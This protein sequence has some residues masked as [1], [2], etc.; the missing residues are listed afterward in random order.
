MTMNIKKAI[1]FPLFA[2]SICVAFTGCK[3]TYYTFWEKLGKEKR[4]LL[5]DNVVKA[6]DEQE[7]AKTEFKDALTR[8]REL[9]GFDGGKLEQAYKQVEKDYKQCNDRAESVRSRITKIEGIADDLFAEWEKE[10]ASYSSENL[11]AISRTKLRETR[12]RF[13]ELRLALRKSAASM[14]PVLAKLKDQTLF[15]KHNLNAQAIGSLKG[16]VISIEADVQKLIAEMN[17]SIAQAEQFIK[18][19]E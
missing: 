16:K 15:L 17:A 4:D 7:A 12:Q 11:R 5:R 8:L 2:V 9:T 14:A 13:E 3:T 1:F 19:L 18:G 6:R 10:L